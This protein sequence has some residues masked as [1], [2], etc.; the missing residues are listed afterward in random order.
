MP[1]DTKKIA[2]VSVA[3]CIAFSLLGCKKAN[4]DSERRPRLEVTVWLD[5]R[6][7]VPPGDIAVS[8]TAPP[9]ERQLFDL[10][11]VHMAVVAAPTEGDIPALMERVVVDADIQG[12]SNGTV[13]VTTGCAKDVVEVFQK[14]LLP[15]WTV[16]VVVGNRCGD[17]ATPRVGAAA[18]VE[19]GTASRV[20]VTFD[21]HSRAF[22]KVEPIP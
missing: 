16:A 10:G 19:R 6:D 5:P 2:L 14:N 15:F 18:V 7:P 1:N 12:H 20:R 11:D 21:R 3:F 17:P 22:I 8:T 13:V 9:K 4:T